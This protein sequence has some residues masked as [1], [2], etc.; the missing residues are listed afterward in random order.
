MIT[1]AAR[2]L[3]MIEAQTLST[4][5]QCTLAAR[6]IMDNSLN[7]HFYVLVSNFFDR[8]VRLPKHMRIA[9]TVKPSSVIYAADTDDQ[10][11]FPIETPLA[12][13]NSKVNATDGTFLQQMFF[14]KT[15]RQYITEP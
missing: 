3:K 12:S 14:R 8:K 15:Y 1:T 6:L 5:R 13:T 4:N 7:L 9:Q 11:A 2:K 10:K